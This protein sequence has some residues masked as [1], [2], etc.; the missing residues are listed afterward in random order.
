[1]SIIFVTLDIVS[2]AIQLTGGSYATHSDPIEKQMKGVH[3][4]MG[5]IALQQFFIFIFL[6]IAAKFHLDMKKLDL[7]KGGQTGW[8]RL[9]WTLYASLG[10]VTVRFAF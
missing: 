3:I 4:Y 2:F 1:M 9:I 7:G 10:F 8:T 6:G 5:G